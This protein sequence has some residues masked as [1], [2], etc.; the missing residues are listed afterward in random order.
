MWCFKKIASG[1]FCLK[2]KIFYSRIKEPGYGRVKQVLLGGGR[3][4][5]RET[6]HTHM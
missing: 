3:A 5:F 4:Q 2:H 6:G 1:P